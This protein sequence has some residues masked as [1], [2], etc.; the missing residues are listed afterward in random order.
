MAAG[1]PLGHSCS[2]TCVT[3][4]TDEKKGFLSN[5]QKMLLAL[6]L[7]ALTLLTEVRSADAAAPAAEKYD[8]AQAAHVLVRTEDMARAFPT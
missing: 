4:C 2:P 1:W 7:T 3:Q 6:A 8:R 5:R